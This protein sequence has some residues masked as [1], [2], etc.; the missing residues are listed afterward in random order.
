MNSGAPVIKKGWL[1][2]LLFCTAFFFIQLLAGTA[3]T[4]ILVLTNQTNPSSGTKALLEQASVRSLAIMIVL[5]FIVSYLLVFVF[6]KFIDRSTVYSLGFQWQGYQMQALTGMM[7]G[8]GTLG[9]GTLILVLLK[10]IRFIG[11]NMD[12]EDL[13][14]SFGLMILVA[15]S[16][17]LVFRGYILNNLMQS[18]NRYTA[19]LISS[20]LFAIVHNANPGFSAL[21]F[22]NIFLAGIFLGIN[23][24]YTKNLWYAMALHFSWNF[25][26]GP[27]LGYQVSGTHLSGLFVQELQG[28]DLITGGKFGFEASIVATGV[29]LT[30][31]AVLALV[32]NK[33]SSPTGLTAHSV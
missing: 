31:S 15:V 19:L 25:F 6:R 21:A 32:Y 27:V 5:S 14:I 10:N 2:V 20:L 4:F 11:W 18:T 23:Y 17:E 24:I 22:I 26:Q 8:I 30:F 7:A 1:R 33:K 13:F 29:I 16:E 3:I 12:G 28:S 9:I